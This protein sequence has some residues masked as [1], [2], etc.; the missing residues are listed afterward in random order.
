[1][2]TF[3]NNNFFSK[4]R[5]LLS[6]FTFLTRSLHSFWNQLNYRFQLPLYSSYNPK[7]NYVLFIWLLVLSPAQVLCCFRI[8]FSLKEREKQ[9]R[10]F[11]FLFDYAHALELKKRTLDLTNMK[12]ITWNIETN[13]FIKQ[14]KCCWHFQLYSMLAFFQYL[15]R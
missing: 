12:K 10:I 4:V 14:V 9:I 3:G 7:T 13:V 1:M 11:S 15:N 5:P 2:N 6:I 8:I